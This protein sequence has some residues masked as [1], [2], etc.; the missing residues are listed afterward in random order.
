MQE[1]IFKHRQRIIRR[2]QHTNQKQNSYQINANKGYKKRRKMGT[3]KTDIA[4]NW[5]PQKTK[6]RK[7]IRVWVQPT[8]FPWLSEL[9]LGQK[10]GNT[11][12]RTNNQSVFFVFCFFFPRQSHLAATRTKMAGLRH[13]TLPVRQ[14]IERI[15]KTRDIFTVMYSIGDLN[16]VVEEQAFGTAC[17]SIGKKKKKMF[18]QQVSLVVPVTKSWLYNL[19]QWPHC[20]GQKQV[21]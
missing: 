21:A 12:P 17:T 3:Y 11:R 19:S 1:N 14:C 5:E 2:R 7:Y 18:V 10:N 8:H 16:T 6:T 15:D 20:Q 9:A 13:I 4:L